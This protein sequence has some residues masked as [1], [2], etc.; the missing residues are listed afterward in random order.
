MLILICMLKTMNA[1]SLKDE[2]G[3]FEESLDR[4]FDL[5]DDDDSM[6]DIYQ[7]VFGGKTS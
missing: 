5:D 2:I 4:N 3:D 7:E 6:D 1:D